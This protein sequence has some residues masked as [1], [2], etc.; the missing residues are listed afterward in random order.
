MPN[1]KQL[2][3]TIFIYLS[4]TSIIFSQNSKEIKVVFENSKNSELF[5]SEIYEI[6]IPENS[7]FTGISAYTKIKNSKNEVYFQIFSEG[8]WLQ[9]VRFEQ[10]NEGVSGRT[11]YN[12]V[13]VKKKFSKIIF[14]SNCISDSSFVFR[15]NFPEKKKNVP[16]RIINKGVACYC[17]MP[18][19]CD[20]NCWGPNSPA[21]KTPT[22][23]IPTH[24]IIHHSSSDT[25]SEDYAAI[26]NNYWDYH[27]N[28]KGWD[29]IAYNWLIDP[30]GIIYQG[31]G[32]GVLG[33]H[34]SC[35]NSYTTG[36]CLIGNYQETDVS[37]DALN[38]LV[39]LIAWEC[40]DKNIN[41]INKSYHKA[42]EL[43]LYNIS[44]HS[45]GNTSTAASSCASGTVCPGKYLYDKLENIRKEVASK[46][47]N[48]VKTDFMSSE[49][50]EIYPIPAKNKIYIT[51]PNTNNSNSARYEIR[52]LIG[53]TLLSGETKKIINKSEI[54]IPENFTGVYFLNLF[55]GNDFYTEMILVE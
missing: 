19:Y 32:S 7:A 24:I 13:I 40:C 11:V 9:P 35:T 3:S 25:Q 21:D 42:S 1:L 26:V 20:R 54:E 12:T 55:D 27:V 31:R 6:E 18:V 53:R 37:Q 36:I 47:C 38:S 4:F 46:D 28:T 10:D 51:F 48:P 30:D 22:S 41:P 39:D 8:N 52:D 17:P 43:E 44:G 23:T 5:I 33:A 49:N 50:F 45:D 2:L 15:L 14:L 16:Q 29:D 34:F